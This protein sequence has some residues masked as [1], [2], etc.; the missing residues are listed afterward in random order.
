MIID[1]QK[2]NI[3][4]LVSDKY[5]HKKLKN[6]LFLSDNQITILKMFSI[7]PNTCNGIDDLMFLIENE[8]D[9]EYDEDLDMVGKEIAEFNYYSNTN[10]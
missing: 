5:M 1:N 6:G 4:D 10:K 2:I 7:D 8:L 9:L 3:D